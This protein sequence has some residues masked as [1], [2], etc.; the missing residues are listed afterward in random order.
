MGTH[1]AIRVVIAHSQPPAL[2]DLRVT[3]RS[4]ADFYVVGEAAN[5]LEAIRLATNPGAHV[6]VADI[7]VIAA[8][9]YYGLRRLAGVAPTV[10][11]AVIAR[12]ARG[13]RTHSQTSSGEYSP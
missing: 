2:D 6:V 12:T 4:D 3:L 9:R 7:S 10:R 8:E 13:E 5:S 1:A 11:V